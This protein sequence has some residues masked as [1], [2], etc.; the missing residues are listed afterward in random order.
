M[1]LAPQRAQGC[2]PETGA[3]RTH[4]QWFVLFYM[5]S[6]TV[7]YLILVAILMWSVRLVGHSPFPFLSSRLRTLVSALGLQA[8]IYL[9][10]HLVSF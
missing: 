1:Q 4:S 10:F 2:T 6:L 8:L 5:R 7:L 3:L 9:R